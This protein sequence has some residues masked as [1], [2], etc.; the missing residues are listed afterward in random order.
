MKTSRP[1]F[2]TFRS[3]SRAACDTSLTVPIFIDADLRHSGFLPLAGSEISPPRE[4]QKNHESEQNQIEPEVSRQFPFLACITE[5]S[6]LD[7]E[8]PYLRRD[9]CDNKP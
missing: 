2:R 1:A 6:S 9:G 8:P 3:Q 4:Q 5:A 7:V